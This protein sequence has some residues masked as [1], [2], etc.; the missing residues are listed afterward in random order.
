VAPQTTVES[1][2]T[3]ARGANNK[4]NLDD[5]FKRKSSSKKG[6]LAIASGGGAT[7]HHNGAAAPPEKQSAAC[8]DLAIVRAA[9]EKATGNRWS[10]LDTE[11]YQGNG[12]YE[13]PVSKII[14]ILETVPHRTP[15]KISSFKYFV[16]EITAIPDPR[17]RAWRKK[18]LHNIVSRI[19]DNAVGGG[20]YSA[21]DLLE[22]VRCACAREDV[23]FDDDIY[24]E[25]VS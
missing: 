8:G 1:D 23:V 7:K 21:M 10:K 15:A 22:D 24:N 6:Q 19:R 16:K 4:E 25:L 3:L 2:A 13:I 5:D 11:A 12:L 9:Y 14:S 20:G 18:K 17:N